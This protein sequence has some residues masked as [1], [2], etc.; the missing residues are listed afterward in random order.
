MG[1]L[2][3]SSGLLGKDYAKEVGDASGHFLHFRS[4]ANGAEGLWRIGLN[5]IDGWVFRPAGNAADQDEKGT[6]KGLFAS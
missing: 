5:A 6:F 3:P 1:A 4:A 2:E